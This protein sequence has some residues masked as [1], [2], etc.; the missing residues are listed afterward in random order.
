M[1]L[2]RRGRRRFRLVLRCLLQGILE[3]ASPSGQGHHST[4]GGRPDRRD[5]GTRDG[6]AKCEG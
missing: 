6:D 3:C 5:V 4:G 1:Y 2:A